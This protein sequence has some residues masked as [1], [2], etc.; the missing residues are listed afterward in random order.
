MVAAATTLRD[1]IESDW[2]L[3]G[4]LSKVSTGSGATLMDEVVQFWDRKQVV[5]NEVPKSVTV[6]KINEN[7]NEIIVKHPHFNEVSDIYEI[8]VYY[9]VVDVE[10][11]NFSTALD[12]IEN[13]A[14]EVVSIIKTVYNPN[15]PT[16]IYF[17][18]TNSWTNEDMYLGNQPELR[19]KLRFQLTTITSDNSGVYPGFTGVLIFDTSESQGDS[20]PTSDYTFLEVEGVKI[21]E[22]YG[23]VPLLTKDVTKGVGVP[24]QM[25]GLFSGTFTAH[26]MAARTNILGSTI[27]KIKNIYKTQSN[28]PIK[29]QIAEVALLHELVNT[30]A[31][32]NSSKFTTQSFMKIDSIF[33]D[34]M[35]DDLAKY[36][37]TGTL[38]RPS[39]FTEVL[40]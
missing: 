32:P 6:E 29:R 28:S 15:V 21:R 4:E 36:I 39:V 11:V 40:S 26:M 23:L 24:F 25:R 9:R 18:T 38:T 8:T 14:Q 34:S 1:T 13:M 20:K 2:D 27:E 7:E 31:S 22:G 3:T 33:K 17:R 10:G 37:I 5:G 16:G 19:R 30:T 35:D 12:L